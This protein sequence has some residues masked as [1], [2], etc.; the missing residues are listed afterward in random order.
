M[1]HR[2][3]LMKSWV[4]KMREEDKLYFS[5]IHTFAD[6]AEALERN[7]RKMLLEA[8][9]ARVN[10][11]YLNPAKVLD[12]KK[13]GFGCGLLCAATIDFL[14][15]IVYPDEGSTER[16]P[17]WLADNIKEF[18]RKDFAKRFYEDFRCG[19][20]HEGRI[21]RTGE[22]SYGTETIVTASDGIIRINPRIL[23]EKVRQAF[24]EYLQLLKTDNQGFETYKAY[25][26]KYFME[27]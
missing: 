4:L 9:A 20:V 24:E 7:D 18:S 19:L 21:K 22:F 17:F 3:T 13:L 25:L 15:K 12:E 6:V 10:G 2:N 23:L 5:P 14:A 11:F 1:N 8:F 27:K 16:I 26:R